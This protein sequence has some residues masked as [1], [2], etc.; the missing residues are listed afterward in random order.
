MQKIVEESGQD[1]I[2]LLG[3]SW[4]T[5]TASR[6][7]IKY[8]ENIGKFVMYAPILSGLGEYEVADDFHHNTWERR[9]FLRQLVQTGKYFGG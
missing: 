9:A 7:V 4:G 1:K 5:V 2:D 8:P 3:W 6:F